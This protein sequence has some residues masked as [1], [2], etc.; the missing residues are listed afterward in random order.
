VGQRRA[1]NESPD[2][3]EDVELDGDPGMSAGYDANGNVLPWIVT[4]TGYV[5]DRWS[6]GLLDRP[7]SE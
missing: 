1:A 3:W 2:T 5:R 4:E 6:V 7:A